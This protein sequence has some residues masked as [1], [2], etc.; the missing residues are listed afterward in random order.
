MSTSTPERTEGISSRLEPLRAAIDKALDAWLPGPDEPP[1][2]LHN[3]MRYSV[4]AGGKRIRPVLAILAGRAV[5][6]QDEAAMPAACALEC[7]HTYS[8][9]HDDLPAMDDDDMR[10]GQPS[11]HKKFDVA[12]AVLAGDAL[13]TAAFE[14]VATRTADPRTANRI[15][16]ELA[17]AAGSVGMVGGQ[18]ADLQA[19]GSEPNESTLEFVHR[20]KTGAL[21]RAAV[22]SGAIAAGGSDDDLAALTAYA[23]NVGLVFQITDDI[24]DETATSEQLGKAAGKDRDKGK[25]TFPAVYGLEASRSEARR[26]ARDATE[27]LAG[28]PAAADPLRELAGYVVSRSS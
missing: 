17:R 18:M 16:A 15:T 6:G 21:I 22:R 25:L 28:L 14:I 10:R 19:D 4:F 9:I 7:I 3:A 5:G 12:T 20:R 8:L 11:N 13:L 26:L 23:E 27:A 24:L 1:A 2:R